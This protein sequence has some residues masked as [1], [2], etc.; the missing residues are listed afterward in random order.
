M[1]ST[2]FSGALSQE[3]TG[4][5]WVNGKLF[6][7]QTCHTAESGEGLRPAGRDRMRSLAGQR[8]QPGPQRGEHDQERRQAEDDRVRDMKTSG[9]SETCTYLRSPGNEA[10]VSLL[11]GDY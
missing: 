9:R 7:G 4:D 3:K 6:G 2:L 11:V 8:A 5:F 10:A 1:N